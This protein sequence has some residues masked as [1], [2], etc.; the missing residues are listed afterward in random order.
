[1]PELRCPECGNE[2]LPR[3]PDDLA[4]YCVCS[5]CSRKVYAW[6]T[7]DVNVKCSKCGK[8]NVTEVTR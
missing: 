2:L 4:D 7:T 5:S 6:E 1:M 3:K 8:E